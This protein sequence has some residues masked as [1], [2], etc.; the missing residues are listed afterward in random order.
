M[1]KW[2][3]TVTF[4][5]MIFLISSFA[6]AEGYPVLKLNYDFAGEVE[7]EAYKKVVNLD[8]AELDIENKFGLGLEYYIPYKNNWE[9]GLGVMY[10]F[11]RNIDKIDANVPASAKKLVEDMDW[12][13]TPFYAI[14]KYNFQTE[15]KYKPYFVGHLGYNIFK[16]NKLERLIKEGFADS[17]DENGGIYYGLGAGINLNEHFLVEIMYTINKATVDG[18]YNGD[19]FEY[20]FDYEKITIGLGYKF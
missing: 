13:M 20:D 6:A 14:A 12:N 1:K 7:G 3:I 19:D 18:D 5:L 9:F 15:N 8:K 4:I 10:Y 17:I 2:Y 16:I 11:E